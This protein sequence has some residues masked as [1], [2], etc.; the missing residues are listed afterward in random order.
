MGNKDEFNPPEYTKRVENCKY[1]VTGDNCCSARNPLRPHIC[2]GYCV[3]RL[4]EW[5][6]EAHPELDEVS[7]IAIIVELTG[8]KVKI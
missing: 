4:G 5:L 8:G 1:R 2:N 7:R 6:K 3:E